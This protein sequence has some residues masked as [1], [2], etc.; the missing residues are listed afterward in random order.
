MFL[1]LSE[2]A[3]K[4]ASVAPFLSRVSFCLHGPLRLLSMR[5]YWH[6]KEVEIEHWLFQCP[7]A[8]FSVIVCHLLSLFPYLSLSVLLVTAAVGEVFFFSL[9]LNLNGSQLKS[10]VSN[11]PQTISMCTFHKGPHFCGNV[12]GI[13][14]HQRRNPQHWCQVQQQLRST[15]KDPQIEFVH[16]NL[17]VWFGETLIELQPW[18]LGLMFCISEEPFW[19]LYGLT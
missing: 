1:C 12:M 7:R 16:N 9:G 11:K 2:P 19:S 6:D 5:F 18:S 3:G 15:A 13:F 10:W 4:L 8:S 14:R 17:C